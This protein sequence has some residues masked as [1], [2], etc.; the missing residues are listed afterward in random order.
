MDNLLQLEDLDQKDRQILFELDE[1][2]RQPYAQIAKKLRISKENVKYR[3]DRLIEQ[4][5]ISSFMIFL[6]LPQ[7]GFP[8]FK[9][10]IRLRNISI[11]DEKKYFEYLINH[12]K[13]VWTGR[14]IGKYDSLFNV[15]CENTLEFN[16]FMQ[17]LR[18]K[19]GS[20]FQ[21]VDVVTDTMQ[22]KK[23]RGYLIGKQTIPERSKP[24]LKKDDLS[25]FDIQLLS[26]LSKNSRASIEEMAKETGFSVVTVR[27]RLR[28]LVEKEV[29]QK[30][31]IRLNYRAFQYQ[32][33]KVMFKLQ[34]SSRK[35]TQ[36]FY[37]YISSFPNAV[38]LVEGIG[39][40]DVEADFEIKD[41]E[42]LNQI[43]FRLKEKFSRIIRDY[44]ILFIT[45]EEKVE[46]VQPNV[47]Q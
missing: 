11:E 29:I 23:E 6:D 45:E 43:I 1:N 12:P 4:N 24:L 9:V 7:M 40:S 34:N 47:I 38:Y 20:F 22:I 33:V 18:E 27:K 25:Q 5:I 17:G 13:V 37:D 44:E 36:S 19:Y 10:F 30:L 42:Q 16:Q 39:I 31:T 15:L 2:S 3:V 32:F 41:I 21:L 14:C 46:Y 28:E 35:E 8:Y 26:T